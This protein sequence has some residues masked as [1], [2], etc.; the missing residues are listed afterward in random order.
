MFGSLQRH[1][2]LIIGVI[3]GGI[4]VARF[5]CSHLSTKCFELF[6]LTLGV[7][8]SSGLLEALSS[9]SASKVIALARLEG[10][11]LLGDIIALS[12]F[13]LV[14][15]LAWFAA[16]SILADFGATTLVAVGVPV[17]GDLGNIENLCICVLAGVLDEGAEA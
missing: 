9:G 11:P 10:V 16:I 4:S 17:I 1:C 12:Q 6:D 5:K 8:T 14:V 15:V 13:E 2:I 7:R 3:R